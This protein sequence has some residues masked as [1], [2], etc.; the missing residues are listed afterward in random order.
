[1]SQIVP[2]LQLVLAVLSLPIATGLLGWLCSRFS[3]ERRLLLLVERLSRILPSLPE[4]S[5]KVEYSERVND[6]LRALNV[7]L[8]PLFKIER[9]RKRIVFVWLVGIVGLAAGFANA[10]H[11]PNGNYQT[12]LGISFGGLA[13]LAFVLI[14]RDTKRQ[15]RALSQVER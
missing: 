3:K 9:R 8:D 2:M 11:I 12:V 7:R 13:V 10:A 14:E 6:A 4:G 5:P 15:R 1:M